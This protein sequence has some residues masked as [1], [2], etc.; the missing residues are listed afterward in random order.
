MPFHQFEPI[1]I[2]FECH[3]IEKNGILVQITPSGHL[4]GCLTL[5]ALSHTFVAN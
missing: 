3:L 1:L 5:F 2:G 4:P